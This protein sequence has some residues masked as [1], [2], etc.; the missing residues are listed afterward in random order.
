VSVV[1]GDL[2]Q[3]FVRDDVAE[4]LVDGEAEV[5]LLSIFCGDDAIKPFDER[6]R[7]DVFVAVKGAKIDREWRGVIVLTVLVQPVKF[8]VLSAVDDRFFGNL[9][10]SFA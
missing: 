6:F 2:L 9:A 3:F 5:G 7:R 8:R 10:S 1:I 4:K